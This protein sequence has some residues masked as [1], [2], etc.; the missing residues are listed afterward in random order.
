MGCKHA[1]PPMLARGGGAIVNTASID[2]LVARGVRTAYG[3]AKAG[4]ML[5]TKNVA[6]QY[7]PR[8]IR[9]NAV[10]PGLVLTPAVDRV[11]PE[12]IEVASR[13]YPMPRLCVPEDLANAVVFLASAEAAFVNGTTLMVDGGA[14]A[15]MPSAGVTAIRRAGGA[16]TGWCRRQ[17][18][19]GRALP[20]QLVTGGHAGT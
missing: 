14:T 4:V 16:R 3:A 6:A 11:T 12:Q 17:P 1:I 7:G 2:G 20:L 5:A 9:C 8:G 10:A 18:A 15:F 13:S 19:N